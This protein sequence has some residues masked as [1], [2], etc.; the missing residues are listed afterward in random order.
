MSNFFRDT[1]FGR[2]AARHVSGLIY[3]ARMTGDLHMDLGKEKLLVDRTKKAF[4]KGTYSVSK[5][6]LL[7]KVIN[8]SI[9]DIN[10]IRIIKEKLDITENSSHKDISYLRK[11]P[12]AKEVQVPKPTEKRGDTVKVRSFGFGSLRDGDSHEHMDRLSIIRAEREAKRASSNIGANTMNTDNIHG[13]NG[14][15]HSNPNQQGK[16]R[17]A[18]NNG[19]FQGKTGNPANGPGNKPDMGKPSFN[20]NNLKL[21]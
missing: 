5:K 21:N 7:E 18:G 4:G 17:P 2:S 9:S 15:S 12:E 14:T 3:G 10:K 11:K 19:T 20:R 1:K 13:N 16:N 6:A 8:P